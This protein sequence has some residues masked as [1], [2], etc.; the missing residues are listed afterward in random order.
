MR[1]FR[2]FIHRRTV[3]AVGYEHLLG[4]GK[5]LCAALIPWHPGGPLACRA[6]GSVRFSG[7]RAVGPCFRDHSCPSFHCSYLHFTAG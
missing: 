7:G 3:V 2:N 1:R 4:R 5:Q 6:G